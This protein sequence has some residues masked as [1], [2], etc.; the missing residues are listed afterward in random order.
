M[1]LEEADCAGCAY[2]RYVCYVWEELVEAAKAGV[3]I[4]REKAFE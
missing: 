2:G 4:R 1:S 3:D